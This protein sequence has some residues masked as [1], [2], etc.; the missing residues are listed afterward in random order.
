MKKVSQKDF[1]C[2]VIMLSIIFVWFITDFIYSLV[3]G[4]YIR[5]CVLILCILSVLFPLI[6][7]LKKYVFLSYVL[8]DELYYGTIETVKSRL[9]KRIEIRYGGRKIKAGCLFAS[10]KVI[11]SANRAVTFVI[12]K[13][14]R[15][16]IIDIL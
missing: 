6:Y 14:G 16:Y 15:V 12:D 1:L 13:T 2:R 5:D 11:S 4:Y 3:L 9:L 8:E 7:V 10:L